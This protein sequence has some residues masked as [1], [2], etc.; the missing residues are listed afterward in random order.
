MPPAPKSTRTTARSRTWT[1]RGGSS[2]PDLLTVPTAPGIVP[3]SA[4][5]E[6]DAWYARD[7]RMRVPITDAEME[8]FHQHVDASPGML[9]LDAGCGTG[10][11]SRRLASAGLGVLGM[12]VSPTALAMARWQG[13]GPHL[14]YAQ[15]DFVARS[16]PAS[17]KPGT[18]DLIMCRN[19]LPYLNRERFLVDAGRWLNPKGQLHLTVPLG[20]C[21]AGAFGQ[22]ERPARGPLAPG[23]STS[24]AGV[25]S[26]PDPPRS[27]NDNPCWEA[28]LR[29][30][31]VH[32]A[33]NDFIL[34]T[35][36]DA[37]TPQDWR[38]TAVRLC[39]R[40]AGIGGDGLV[41][42]VLSSAS[43]GVL[44]VACYNADGSVATMCGN[45]LRSAAWC[46]AQSRGFREMTLVMN[47]VKHDAVVRDDGVSVTAEVGAVDMRLLRAVWNGRPFWFDSAHTGTEHVVAI[48]DDVDAVDT[49]TFG[50]L[51]RHHQD[52]APLGSNVNFVQVVG[53]QALKI[54]TYERGVEAE[55]L[56]CGSGAVAAV[57]IATRRGLICAKTTTVH[58]Q[59]GTPLV[60][61]P[62]PERPPGRTYWINGPVTQVFEGELA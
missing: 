24:K 3:L 53:D 61:S 48:V 9:A 49:K 23:F 8:L 16:I 19:A 56:S 43:A 52:L 13:S 58:N 30:L 10:H 35:G 42:S 26:I 22:I 31:K 1:A 25:W 47:G 18:F 29:F 45:A 36:P 15:H 51:V 20:C 33:G 6:W 37:D 39:D 12:D 17:L 55:T 46:A 4:A 59:A 34:V 40:R 44:N 60:V 27:P 2:M 57:V 28:A 62:H 50:K 7:A 5:A 21:P 41:T 14:M 38:T 54:R 11:W 32:G